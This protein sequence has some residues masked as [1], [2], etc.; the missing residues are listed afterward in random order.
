M[1]TDPQDQFA[2][3]YVALGN[4]FVN[5]VDPDGEIWHFI[6]A[7]V[8]GGAQNVYENIGKIDSWQ[9]GV[10]YFVSGVQVER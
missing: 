1:A 9:S 5:G 8:V 10:G 7:A 3:P 4:N 6:V 2:S